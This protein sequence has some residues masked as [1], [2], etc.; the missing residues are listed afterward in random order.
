MT[1]KVV[2]PA[3]EPD[4]VKISW[5]VA[6]LSFGW[7]IVKTEA[8]PDEQRIAIKNAQSKNLFI[9]EVILTTIPLLC[10]TTFL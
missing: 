4:R 1:V 3:P 9:F 6:V 5:L 10:K 7:S 8:P 2:N